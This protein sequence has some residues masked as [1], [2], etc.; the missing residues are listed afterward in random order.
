MSELTV[1]MIE[2]FGIRALV[3]ETIVEDFKDGK[4]H[5]IITRERVEFPRCRIC[6][7]LATDIDDRCDEHRGVPWP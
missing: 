6:W 4:V 1:D 3:K 5:R 2:A 7:A